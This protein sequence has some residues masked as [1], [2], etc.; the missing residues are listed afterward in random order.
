MQSH[1]KTTK[2]ILWLPTNGFSCLYRDERPRVANIILKK[3]D[4]VGRLTL[5]NLKTYYKDTVINT[6]W[7]W[8][9]SRHTDH[10]NRVENSETDT[11]K[12]I[13]LIFDKA[14]KAIQ[15]R[16][17]SIINVWYENN[18]TPVCK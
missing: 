3:N 10:W 13:Q 4:K 5:P 12:H 14:A 7:H 11:H 2:G 9:K 17:D 6:V 1:S 18:W 15:C 16:R 8:Q